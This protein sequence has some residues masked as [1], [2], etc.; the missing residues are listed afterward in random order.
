MRPSLRC[1]HCCKIGADV[2]DCDLGRKAEHGESSDEA[3]S[4]ENGNRA[5]IHSN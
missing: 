5:T 1:M 4:V 3:K 2:A